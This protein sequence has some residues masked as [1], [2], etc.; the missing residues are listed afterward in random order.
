[1]DDCQLSFDEIKIDI[2]T[3]PRRF[4]YMRRPALQERNNKERTGVQKTY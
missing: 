2:R 1:M 4:R 3:V